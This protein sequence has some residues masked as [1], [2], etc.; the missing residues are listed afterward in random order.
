MLR[1]GDSGENPQLAYSHEEDRQ[2]RL[3]GE[4]PRNTTIRVR[5]EKGRWAVLVRN[6]ARTGFMEDL[7]PSRFAGGF[8]LSQRRFKTRKEAVQKARGYA[9][10]AEA[11]GHNVHL[12]VWKADGSGITV[13]ERTGAG[14]GR[15]AS[16]Q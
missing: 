3:R 16:S 8:D 2:V 1:A 6:D 14:E 11:K 15:R 9:K 12:V 13:D 10:G 4:V 5:K 7:D